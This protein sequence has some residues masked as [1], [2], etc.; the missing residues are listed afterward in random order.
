MS[1]NLGWSASSPAHGSVGQRSAGSRSQ[2][3]LRIKD[4]VHSIDAADLPHRRD[5]Q[6]FAPVQQLRNSYEVSLRNI[7]DNIYALAAATAALD[8]V[9]GKLVQARCQIELLCSRGEEVDLGKVE[10]TLIA[11]AEHVN[12]SVQRADENY[13]NLLRD[14]RLQMQISEVGGKEH[15]SMQVDLTMISLEKLI[16]WKLRDGPTDPEAWIDLI[17][18][19][20]HVTLQN[21]QILS[22]LIL[23]LF[24]ARDYTTDVVQLV[25]SP[26]SEQPHPAKPTRIA[27]DF[28]QSARAALMRDEPVALT[29]RA[30]P[31]QDTVSKPPNRLMTFLN[32]VTFQA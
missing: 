5:R 2:E 24:A 30:E 25:M 7:D 18:T 19:M 9:E 22:S 1:F 28:V 31:R 17:D 12:Q 14:S 4:L 6:V 16:A 21:V 27:T 29:N 13:V 32:Q 15:R 20:S 3:H 23:T 10:R 8:R 11:L 26:Q